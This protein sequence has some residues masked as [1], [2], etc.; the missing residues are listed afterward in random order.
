MF[1]YHVIK[2]EEN[3]KIEKKI[4]RNKNGGIHI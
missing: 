4:K 3:G 2:Y 1:V